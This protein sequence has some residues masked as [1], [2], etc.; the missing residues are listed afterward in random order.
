MKNT[1]IALDRTLLPPG[2]R[3]LAAVSGGADSVCLLHLLR[4]LGDVECVCAHYDHR[5]RPGSAADAAFV[6]RL[7]GEWEI[8]LIEGSGDVAAWAA[9]YRL[10][11]ETAAR[12][13]RYAFLESAADRVGADRIATAHN[14]SDNA[15]T[16]LFH[17]ARGTG[18]RGL[19]G[20]PPRRGRIVRPLLGVSRERILAYLDERGIPHVEDE[21]NALDDGARNYARHHILPAMENLHGGALENIGRM[22]RSLA[23]D[24]AFLT[25]LAV[26]WLESQRPGELSA[27]GL[28][29]LPRPVAARALR[30]FLGSDL[31][32][33][34]IE[35]ALDLCTAGPSAVLELP[36]RRL[37]R[38]NDAIVS[39]VPEPPV[40]SERVLTPGVP[41]PLPEA[42]LLCECRVCGSDEE[43]QISFNIFSFSCA[44]ICGKLSIAR[45]AEGDRLS[46]LGR[47]GTRS[48]KKWM[49]DRKIPRAQRDCV[50]VL[51]DEQGLLAVF[52]MGQGDRACAEPGKPFY[53]IT[54]RPL[55]EENEP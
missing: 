46:L 41:L 38:R 37:R 5:L 22:T 51:R 48:V 20:I 43:I 55:S 33:E 36:G 7:C 12:E 11:V 49:I 30:L 24:E 27:A 32:A 4:S 31:S 45:R 53:K 14:L 44:N 40:L 34:R 29:A 15:E 17:M 50:P 3:V 6:R 25:S 42:G 23:E 47:K 1:D 10:S 16:V 35:A 28:R 19:T 8:P 13:L 18:L 2:S 26:E 39:D 21:T 52:G 54:F 9:E